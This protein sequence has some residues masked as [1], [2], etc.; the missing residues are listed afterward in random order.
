MN[1]FRVIDHRYI[2]ECKSKN[3]YFITLR[4]SNSKQHYESPILDIKMNDQEKQLF[5]Y[6]FDVKD[7]LTPKKKYTIKKL[8]K[9]IST[10]V[11]LD[12]SDLKTNLYNDDIKEI[13][14]HF[15]EYYQKQYNKDISNLNIKLAYDGIIYCGIHQFKETMI[16]VLHPYL[17]NK[18]NLKAMVKHFTKTNKNP[19]VKL[20]IHFQY[21][22]YIPKS[23][24]QNEKT[25]SKDIVDLDEE[26][27]SLVNETVC[28]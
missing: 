12:E 9:S 11:L 3:N 5:N 22:L 4:F 10:D 23:Q 27:Q 1:S 8:P 28:E 2:Y 13:K 18:L 25:K 14:E 6:N 17:K 15:I 21:G 19:N 26:T 20:E 7:S 24:R 16:I